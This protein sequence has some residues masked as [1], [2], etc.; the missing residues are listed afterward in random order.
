VLQLHAPSTA[1]IIKQAAAMGMDLPVVSGSAIGQPGTAALLE[2]KELAGVCAES[3]SSPISGGSPALQK[4]TADYRQTFGGEPDAYALAQYDG[5]EMMLAAVKSGAT[6]PE[7]VRQALSTISYDGLAMTYK[8][9]GRG[10]MAHSAVILCYDGA[11]RVPKIVQSYDNI[12]A[13]M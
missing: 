9:D 4:F 5:T 2:P 8:S 12:D 13:S 11:S 3:A 10:N 1:L 6:T 7:A